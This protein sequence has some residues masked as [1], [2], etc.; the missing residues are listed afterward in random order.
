MTA[1]SASGVVAHLAPTTQRAQAQ[2]RNVRSVSSQQ[3]PRIDPAEAARLR[4]RATAFK[5]QN[6]EP[7]QL[8]NAF[9]DY[10]VLAGT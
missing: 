6:N 1:L 9:A 8:G 2:L 4:D 3:L 10:D 5:L 7:Y